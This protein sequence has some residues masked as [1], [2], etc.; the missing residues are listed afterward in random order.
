MDL[1]MVALVMEVD[2]DIRHIRASQERFIAHLISM[3]IHK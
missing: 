1:D 2:M 3:K